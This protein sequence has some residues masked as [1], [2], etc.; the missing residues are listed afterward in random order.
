V[1]VVSDRS[2]S[3]PRRKAKKAEEIGRIILNARPRWA[4]E[5][6]RY[7]NLESPDARKDG[8]KNNAQNVFSSQRS[9]SLQKSGLYQNRPFDPAYLRPYDLQSHSCD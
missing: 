4:Q 7:Y 8:S 6:V 2:P 9:K 5:E 1:T 3:E